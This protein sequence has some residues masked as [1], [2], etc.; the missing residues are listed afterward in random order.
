VCYRDFC[1]WEKSYQ[2]MCYDTIIFHTCWYR[3]LVNQ[4]FPRFFF[5]IWVKCLYN[6]Q[7]N[8][9]LGDMNLSSGVQARYPPTYYFLCTAVVGQLVHWKKHQ[10]TKPLSKFSQK[11]GLFGSPQNAIRTPKLFSLITNVLQ[12]NKKKELN[13]RYSSVKLCSTDNTWPSII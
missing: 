9:T 4:R 7:N 10:T 1:H 13:K 6:K 2:H 8:M 11:E 5:W 12:R 3:V